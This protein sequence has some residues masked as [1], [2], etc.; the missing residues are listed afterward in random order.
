MAIPVIDFSRL[1]GDERA[2][3][4]AE[5]AAGFEEWGF[6]QLVNTGIPDELLER[7]KKVCGD[8][9]K[10]REDR[11][12]ES[13]PAVKALARLVNQEGEGLA[14]KKIE[15]MDWEDV[16]TLQ[17][18]LPWP[19][20][21]PAFKET[22]MEYR[23]E[24]KKLG[25]KLLGVME[26]LLG[27]QEGYIRR[28]FTGDGDFEPFYGTKVSHYPPCPRPELVD[29][30]RAHTDAGG[31]ILLF[32]DDRFGGL[33]MLRND[34]GHAGQ[35]LDVQPV[36]NAIVVN[37]GDQIEVLSNGRFKSA[38]HRI[39]ATRDG[40]RRSIA[41]FYNPARMATIAPAIPT[42]SGDAAAVAYPSFKFG[43]YMEVYVK[44]KFQGK[45]PRFA[46][47]ATK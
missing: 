44:H 21:P 3:T 12:K 42:A 27:L 47:L 18:D 41:S 31:L 43:D 5:I 17:D 10:L 11:F 4:L 13:N 46:A 8:I 6:F 25:E 2:A 28:V 33:Q 39:L 36:E 24:L 22:M 30:L 34:G 38:W 29:G 37:T 35:W 19:S 32:Q 9:Y 40:N 7:V 15:D 16:F 14:M 45:E 26:E 23:R 1:D 20:N